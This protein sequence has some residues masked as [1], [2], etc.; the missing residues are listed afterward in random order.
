MR[1][2]SILVQPC[3][4]IPSRIGLSA[5]LT[6]RIRQTHDTGFLTGVN[7]EFPAIGRRLFQFVQTRLFLCSCQ[8]LLGGILFLFWSFSLFQLQ[9]SRL[10]SPT[11]SIIFP[12]PTADWVFYHQ[13]ELNSKRTWELNA[14]YQTMTLPP[15]VVFNY[16]FLGLLNENTTRPPNLA[17]PEN[18]LNWTGHFYVEGLYTV[19]SSAYFAWCL[20]YIL[21]CTTARWIWRG[22][23][24]SLINFELL[25]HYARQL[26]SMYDP[27][28]DV[29]VKG[30]CIVNGPVYPQGGAG[31]VLSR[32]AVELLE[33]WGDYSVWGFFHD[34]PDK[35]QGVI[36]EKILPEIGTLS[37]TAFLG[38]SFSEHEIWMLQQQ[39]FSDLEPCPDVQP[40]QPGRGCREM[41]APTRQIVFFH[42]GKVFH[43]G[44]GYLME[45][46]QI[47]NNLWTAPPD[48]AFRSTGR[49]NKGLCRIQPGHSP[50]V[51]V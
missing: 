21:R 3:A 28:R 17:M 41:T 15:N 37:S 22:D 14:Y 27:L 51:F 49:T 2:S 12:S 33:V 1:E 35:R 8:P 16:A 7:I 47:A 43:N 18:Y 44:P 24:D 23:D 9:F 5:P 40:W 46:W 45:R 6:Q 30:D 38:C 36:L 10:D 50:T 4:Y 26:N 42:I 34:E 20:T 31:V 48:V 29:V 19:R 25:P 13:S 39:N 32:R 11:L